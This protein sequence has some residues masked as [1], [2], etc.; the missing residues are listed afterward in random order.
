MFSVRSPHHLE[1]FEGSQ[2]FTRLFCS[3]LYLEPL[4]AGLQVPVLVEEH[5]GLPQGSSQ[6]LGLPDL[7]LVVDLYDDRWRVL[8]DVLPPP[9][10]QDLLEDQELV[11]RGREGLVNHLGHP[12]VLAADDPG[13]GIGEAGGVGADQATGLVHVSAELEELEK[14]GR[15]VKSFLLGV[16][17]GGRFCRLTCFS[18]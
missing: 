11:P 1:H 7:V 4:E 13:E 6:E 3:P 17:V 10:D 15:G 18:V 14:G 12:A 9:V 8:P 16:K 5:P 2:Q